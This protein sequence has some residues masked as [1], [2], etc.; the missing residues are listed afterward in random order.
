MHNLAVEFR[1]RNHG[2]ALLNGIDEESASGKQIQKMK[3]VSSDEKKKKVDFSV[4][5]GR[6][7]KLYR[8]EIT[9]TECGSNCGERPTADWK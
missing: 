5:A 3:D 4:S 7:Y 2:V 8:C 6:S 1:R 9:S